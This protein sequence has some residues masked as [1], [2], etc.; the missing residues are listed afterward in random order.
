MTWLL[1]RQHRLSFALAAV[2][3]AAFAVPVA[4]TGRHL[5]AALRT[6]RRDASCSG[7]HVLQHYNAMNAVTATTVLVPLLLGV[8]WGATIVGKELDT[9]TATLVWT[10]SVTRR[11]W[12]RAKIVTLLASTVLCSGAVAALVSWWSQARNATVEPRFVGLQ[13]DIQGIVPV[14]YAVFGAALGLAAG[15]LWRRVLPAMATTLVGFI[16]VRFFVELVLRPHYA[17]PVTRTT[18]LSSPNETPPGSWTMHSELTHNGQVV[19]GP[20]RAPS[21]CTGAGSRDAMNGCLD[22][23]GYQMRITYQP[24]GRFWSFQFIETAIF[25][26]LAGLLVLLAVIALRRHDA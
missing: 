17:T 20:I 26:G 18:P 8:F 23:S 10:Q 9:G 4:V 3:L 11:R 15:I 12:L 19:V 25:L 21:T 2:L 7:F 13:F 1:W 22:G 24:A 5:S 6:C 16:A 14:A